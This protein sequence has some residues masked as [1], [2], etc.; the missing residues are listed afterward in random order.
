MADST[1]ARTIIVSLWNREDRCLNHGISKFSGRIPLSPNCYRTNRF[2]CPLPSDRPITLRQQKCSRESV[3]D[4]KAPSEE[5]EG[6]PQIYLL[7]GKEVLGR[8]FK[9]FLEHEGLENWGHWLVRERGMK[10]SGC[11]NCIFWWVSSSWGPSDQ[12][13]RW[14]LLDRLVSVGVTEI[15]WNL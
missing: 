4:C 5:M 15:S 2:V 10:S 3:N 7:W 8:V 9:R 11:E 12:L 6:D 14:G 13:S 1:G